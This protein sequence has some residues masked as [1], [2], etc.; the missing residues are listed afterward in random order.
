MKNI[1]MKRTL[2]NT[3][4]STENTNILTGKNIYRSTGTLAGDYIEG[5]VL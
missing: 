3:K 4:K 1:Y 2:E 5:T